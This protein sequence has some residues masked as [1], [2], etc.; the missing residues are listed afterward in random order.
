MRQSW[1]DMLGNSRHV[2]LAEAVGPA[3]GHSRDCNHLAATAVGHC[4]GA[5]VVV[6]AAVVA[7]EV[8]EAGHE[9]ECS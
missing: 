6:V 4:R 5:G 8:V 2:A 9:R 1:S 7:E 3:G